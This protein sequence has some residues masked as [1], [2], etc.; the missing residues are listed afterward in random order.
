MRAAQAATKEVKARCFSFIIFGVRI[1]VVVFL[2][3][4]SPL[5]PRENTAVNIRLKMG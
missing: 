5:Q 2:S 1:D 4:C 3:E